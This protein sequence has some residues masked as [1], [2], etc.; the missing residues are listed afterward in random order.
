MNHMHGP[1]TEKGSRPREQDTR[2]ANN[3]RRIEIVLA[4]G[5]RE[6]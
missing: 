3:L 1:L 6:T 4:A 2:D 5:D